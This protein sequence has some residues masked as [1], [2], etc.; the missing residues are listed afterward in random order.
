MIGM[1]P[2]VDP[3][4]WS[5]GVEM[6][7]HSQSLFSWSLIETILFAKRYNSDYGPRVRLPWIIRHFSQSWS[8]FLNFLKSILTLCLPKMDRYR[9][10]WRHPKCNTKASHLPVPCWRPLATFLIKR[11][12]GSYNS[13]NT[14]HPREEKAME[15]RLYSRSLLSSW[16][17]RILY[18]VSPLHV[19]LHSVNLKGSQRSSGSKVMNSIV[20]LMDS[21]ALLCATRSKGSK[22]SA[23]SWVL[24]RRA[25]S[26]SAPL[27]PCMMLLY[28]HH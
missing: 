18:I 26:I 10:S 15:P 25:V 16:L 6:K 19:A 11:I 8:F 4:K 24:L 20:S 12:Q 5:F 7:L 22:L 21:K 9:S 27:H 2:S 17:I 13:R 3:I 23:K 28:L 14:N 1:S